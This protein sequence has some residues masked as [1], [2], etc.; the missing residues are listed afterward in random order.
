M[1]TYLVRY[2]T[3]I[4]IAVTVEAPDEDAAAEASRALA[5]EY[6]ETV[7]G[8]GHQVRA[9]VSLDGMGADEIEAQDDSS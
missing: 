6:A 4:E 7:H 8:D 9:A 3:S 1:G 2:T 5:A